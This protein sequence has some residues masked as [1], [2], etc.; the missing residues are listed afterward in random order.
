MGFF[1]TLTELPELLSGHIGIPSHLDGA[2]SGGELRSVGLQEMGLG[3]SKQMDPAQLDV[4]VWEHA[5]G[6]AEQTGK[7]SWTTIMMR[8]RPLSMRERST[9]FHSCRSSRP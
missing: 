9:V 4:G 7:S 6:E 2:E 5:T 8:R 3:V 1:E